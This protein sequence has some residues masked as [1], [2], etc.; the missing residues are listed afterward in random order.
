MPIIKPTTTNFSLFQ[1]AEFQ[2]CSRILEI[3]NNRY[4]QSSTI[5]LGI[6][7]FNSTIAGNLAL[8]ALGTGALGTAVFGT[9]VAV[10]ICA[11]GISYLTKPKGRYPHS[12]IY[13]IANNCDHVLRLA[14]RI[15]LLINTIYFFSYY[16]E[17]L[18]NNQN[19][20]AGLFLTLNTFLLAKHHLEEIVNTLIFMKRNQFISFYDFT[21]RNSHVSFV[22]KCKKAW[23]LHFPSTVQIS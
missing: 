4:C 1:F 11:K 22:D 18:N 16:L 7:V 19:A 20:S 14:T 3:F 23:S 9:F 17:S 21:I 10:P 15:T 13:K 12:K 8:A 2:I 5:N 6:A